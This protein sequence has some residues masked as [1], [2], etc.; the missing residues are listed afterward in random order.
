MSSKK[1]TFSSVKLVITCEHG[2]YEI[3][4]KYHNLFAGK[5][6][7]LQSHR[8]YDSG[9]ED[10]F[11]Y[12]KDLADFSKKNTMS[13]LLIEFNRSLHHKNVFSQ[14]SQN[15]NPEEKKELI[16]D[17]YL[18]YR[19]SVENFIKKEISN[20][21]PVFHLSLHSFTP[22]LSNEIRNN[23]IGLLYDS[24]RSEEKELCQTFKSSLNSKNPE[25]KIRYNYPYLGSAD[26]FT[27]Y[28][29]K[30]FPSNYLGV[31]LEINQKLA[32]NNAFPIKLK[33]QLV[34]VVKGLI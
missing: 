28:L 33:N 1:R 24:K 3:P 26:G 34:Q 6:N 7:I 8:G 27:T 21:N 9:T 22:Q 25:L 11:E 15:L 31:E 5:K 2:G 14:F 4:S 12:C 19:S 18:P 16:N 20:G 17:Y 23:D 32:K 13:R 29:R 30:I 10:L